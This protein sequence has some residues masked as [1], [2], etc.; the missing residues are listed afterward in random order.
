M[1]ME[2]IQV[3]WHELLEQIF[4]PQSHGSS[5][6]NLASIGLAVSKKK[7]FENIEPEWRWTKNN[8]WP[9]SYIFI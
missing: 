8:V 9:W 2:A 5:K 6:W 3:V 4:V 1:G 7:K